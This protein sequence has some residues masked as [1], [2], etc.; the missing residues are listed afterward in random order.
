M[1]LPK[2]LFG[3]GVFAMCILSFAVAAHAQYRASIQ[4]VLTDPQGEA[5]V[6]ATVTL[7]NDET[8]QKQTAPSGE[9]GVYNFNGLPPSK[10]TITVE[11]QGF[12]T[13]TIKSVGVIAEQANSINVQLEIG[14]IADTVT[15]NGDEVPPTRS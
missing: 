8:G 14:Q 9:G 6:G 5:V 1:K 15:V 7:T 3:M 4:G 11:K 10:F 2:F 12:K 13:K